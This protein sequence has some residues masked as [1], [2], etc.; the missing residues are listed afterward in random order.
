MGADVAILMPSLRTERW[1]AIRENLAETTPGANLYLLDDQ[2]E[3]FA[4]AINEGWQGTEEPFLFV[5]ADDV[6]FHEGWLE[7][8]LGCMEGDVRVVGTNDLGNHYVL[9]GLHATHYLVDRRYIEDV[10]GVIDG[11]P[12]SFLY[13]Y[14]H[15][16][17][18]AEFVETAQSRG[19]FA[20]CLESVVEHLHPA[21]GKRPEDEVHERT[22]DKIHDDWATFTE[23]RELWANAEV[24][25]LPYVE[26]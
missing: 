3:S 1:E 8:A 12:G 26:P 9:S 10:G 16:Y 21:F 17:T 25:G 11:G 18:D 13:T 20:P 23:R 6:L 7:A 22:V 15:N 24:G 4:D 14:D 2:F 5:G 19:V